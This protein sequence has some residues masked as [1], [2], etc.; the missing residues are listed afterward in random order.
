MRGG[1]VPSTTSNRESGPVWRVVNTTTLTIS[2]R[3]L[4][5]VGYRV[6]L[7]SRA[8]IS[9]KQVTTSMLR[10]FAA[11]VICYTTP[12]GVKGKNDSGL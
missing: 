2:L 4:G 12:Q 3:T 5:V 6:D 7:F 11:L 9:K 10:C 8:T 1:F